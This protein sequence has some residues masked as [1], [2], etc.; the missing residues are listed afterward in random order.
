MREVGHPLLRGS[1][2]AE[3]VWPCLG[4]WGLGEEDTLGKDGRPTG[5]GTQVDRIWRLWG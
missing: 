3:T 5:A 4:C 1:V 2:R